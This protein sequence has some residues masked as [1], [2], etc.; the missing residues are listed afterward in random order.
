MT[1]KIIIDTNV[2]IYDPGCIKKFEDCE[3]YVPLCILEELDNAKRYHDEVSRNAQIAIKKLEG[4]SGDNK[5]EI[6]EDRLQVR[7]P[8]REGVDICFTSDAKVKNIEDTPDNRIIQLAMDLGKNGNDV[9]VV[10][11]DVNVR[12]KCKLFGV[13]SEDFTKDSLIEESS[14]V[15]TGM[16]TRNV[17]P[18]LIDELF[19]NGNIKYDGRYPN[20]M[21]LLKAGTQSA[22]GRYLNSG[23]IKPVKEK[24]MWGIRPRNVEQAAAIDMLNEQLIQLVTLIGRAGCGKTIIALACGLE[25]VLS[26]KRYKKLI[27]TR[28]IEPMGRD[29]GYLPG[30]QPLDAKLLTLNGWTNMGNIKVG[31]YIMAK[32]GNP[33]KILGIFPKGKK[34]VYRIRTSDGRQTECCEDHL[35]I[36][37]TLE[38]KKNNRNG[39]LKTTKEI[40][41]TLRNKKFN[42]RLNH[43]LPR[44]EPVNFEEKKLPIKPYTLGVLLGDGHFG[45]SISLASK[46]K[47]IV[48]RV[49]DEIKLLGCSL[50]HN[51][52]TI[53][54]NLS[55]NL[56][57]NKPARSIIITNLKTEE[58]QKY[59]SIGIALNNIDINRSTLQSRCD[60]KTVKDNIKYEF[61][62]CDKRWQNPIKEEIHK[63]GLSNFRSNNK[64]IPKIYLYSSIN[65]RLELL[66]GLMDADGCVKKQTGEASFCTVSEKMAKDVV[67]IVHSLGGNANI[68]TRE[69]RSHFSEKNGRVINGNYDVH[70]ISI[71]LPESMNPFYLKRKMDNYKKDYIYGI[72]IESIELV[73][74]KEVQCIKIENPEH[75][76]IT[77]DY[78]ITHNTI[79]EKM[80]PWMGAIDDNLE[81]LFQKNLNTLDDYKNRGIIQ[82]E[83]LTY[84]RGR[85]FPKSF[86]IIDEA[87]NLSPEQVK[88]IITRVGEGTKIVLTGDIEQID[89]P[90]FD[91]SNNGLTCVVEKFKEFAISGHITLMKG[92]RS[93]LATLAS[94]IL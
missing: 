52:K 37:K 20:E 14:F 5:S 15:Y 88:T 9:I 65:Q 40:M 8:V 45:N 39:S 56:Y 24:E 93:E 31:D 68:H 16:T 80:S 70:E 78:I 63:L 47:D 87:Q 25:Q 57:N 58:T 32:D 79:N 29:L 84:I 72:K 18:K 3:I 89:S 12:L 75:L 19:N 28:P 36:T 62:V 30:P 48:C 66:R 50:T 1:K 6:I 22:V 71:S 73:G 43:F 92:E 91:F 86:I 4:F 34:S 83:P 76:Y 82:V 59:P 69:K 42:N 46:D 51:D 74:E 35:W 41:E 85:S 90:Y 77:D 11:R 67:E 94:K 2:Y 33:T 64:F 10:S 81:V 27:V 26:A 55:S 23:V 53:N 54:Y 17:E 21:F 60:N 61:S 13:K 49:N 38:D 44:N 7:V